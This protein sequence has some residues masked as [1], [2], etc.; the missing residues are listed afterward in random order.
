MVLQVGK[1]EKNKEKEEIRLVCKKNRM[2]YHVLR[3]NLESSIN[4]IKKGW[5]KAPLVVE[6]SQKQLNLNTALI[7]IIFKAKFTKS[8]KR[9][10]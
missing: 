2:K 5:H 3:K 9:R 7:A 4:F 1:L 10:I 8:I 6:W